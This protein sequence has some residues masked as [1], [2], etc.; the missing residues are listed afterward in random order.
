[1][2][3]AIIARKP[4][5]FAAVFSIWHKQVRKFLGNGE[6]LFGVMIQPVLWVVL[7]GVGMRSIVGAAAGANGYVGYMIPGIVALSAMGGA[8]GGGMVWLDERVRGIVKEY[9]AAPIPRISILLG[10]VGSTLSK[11]L[12]QALVIFTVGI[13]MG[14]DVTGSPIGW[15]MGIALLVGYAAGFSGLALAVASKTDDLMAYHAMIMLLN[16]P[17]L[18]LS[19][20][21][22]PMASM[23]G[24]M[25]IGSMINPTSYLVDGFRQTVLA[26]SAE[27]PLWLCLAVTSGFAVL[28]LLAASR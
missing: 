27:L 9:L 4:G 20:A 14:A 25:K 17:V 11:A 23:P 1:M 6:E 13:A 26:G 8:I 24:W 7:F 3:T 19:N 15:L 16:L 21:L 22:Y 10:N 12:V 2:N 28:G 5:L 18:F